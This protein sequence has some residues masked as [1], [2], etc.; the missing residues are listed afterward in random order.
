V[1]AVRVILIK[2][3]TTVEITSS[4]RSSRRNDLGLR[5]LAAIVILGRVRLH[6]SLTLTLPCRVDPDHEHTVASV[7]VE[8]LKQ[9]DEPH[10]TRRDGL[11]KKRVRTARG[12]KFCSVTRADI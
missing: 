10:V 2:L 11:Q 4:G 9:S 5:F 12:G 8:R 1:T 7:L 3:P 6:G